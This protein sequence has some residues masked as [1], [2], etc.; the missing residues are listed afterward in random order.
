VRIVL[1]NLAVGATLLCIFL[2]TLDLNGLAALKARGATAVATVTDLE[3]R[4]GKSTT[5]RVDY[6]FSVP[7]RVINGRDKIE[8]GEYMASRIGDTRTVTYLPGDPDTFRLGA[9]NDER[10]AAQR[11]RWTGGLVGIA[12]L[13]GGICALVEADYRKHLRLLREG[14]PVVARV[15]DGQ[16]VRGN[17]PAYYL[18][19]R[20]DLTQSVGFS[21]KVQVNKGLYD[22]HETGALSEWTVLYDPESPD[23]NLPYVCITAA[24]LDAAR[25]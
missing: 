3:E 1:T 25:R 14:I 23:K 20:F 2:A 18:S 12:A 21:K 9:V 8:R 19:Y 17:T 7:G 13:L 10:I 6:V 16:V 22:L 24:R 4:R 11:N 5:Y 15:T